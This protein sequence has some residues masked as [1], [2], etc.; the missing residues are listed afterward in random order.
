[1][2]I[3]R[4]LDLNGD[5]TFGQGKANYLQGTKQIEQS[6]KTRLLSFLGD[7]FFDPTAGIDWF[8]LLGS[9][10]VLELR[11]AINAV[12]LNTTGVTGVVELSVN[13]NPVTRLFSVSYTVTTVYT[14]ITGTAATIGS[15]ANYLLTEGGLIITTED[16][17][18]I[19]I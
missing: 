3:V 9:K 6:I 18:R 1:M 8:N 13:L 4:A 2:S 19:T 11:L 17:S 14:G 15:T 5:W 7:C 10:R 12:L 16:G